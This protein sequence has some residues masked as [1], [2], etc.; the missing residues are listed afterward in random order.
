MKKNIFLIS[1]LLLL[2]HLLF[3]QQPVLDKRA[4][5]YYTQ[6]EINKMPD[7]K[8][9]QVNFLYRNSFII[10]KEFKGQINPDSIDIRQY[11]KQRLPYKRAKVYLKTQNISTKEKD[12]F[13][14]QYIYLLS[15][16][17]LKAAYENIK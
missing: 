1:F 15:I 12:N 5:A 8:I 11:S 10:P 3:S 17:E 2:T 9:K 7:Y 16:E 4:Y 14:G 6:E 13:N